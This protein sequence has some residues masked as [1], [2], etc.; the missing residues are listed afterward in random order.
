MVKRHVQ[1]RGA[2]VDVVGVDDQGLGQLARG[3]GEL[4]QDQH[5]ALVFARGDELLGHQV[6]AVVQA[7]DEAQV[8]AAIVF[9]DLAARGA[10]S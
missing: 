2:L 3:T 9:V 1:R 8:G 4:R 5:A 6:H 10:R 7:A